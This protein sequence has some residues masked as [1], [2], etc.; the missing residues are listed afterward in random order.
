MKKIKTIPKLLPKTLKYT[1]KPEKQ[2]P[3]IV[4]Y[5]RDFLWSYWPDSN[6]RPAH[7]GALLCQ[8]SHSSIGKAILRQTE[9]ILP[10]CTAFYGYSV[11]TRPLILYFIL[12]AVKRF[13]FFS[14]NFSIAA[15]LRKIL[16]TSSISAFVRYAF[17][18]LK[19]F[20]PD[21][22]KSKTFSSSKESARRSFLIGTTPFP[23]TRIRPSL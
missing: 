21:M 5:S 23:G 1:T 4:F 19:L 3:A 20:F 10:F 17:G 7:Y 9:K 11:L 6:R 18:I 16:R 13:F 14:L 8:L 2:N 12:L 15:I 22:S